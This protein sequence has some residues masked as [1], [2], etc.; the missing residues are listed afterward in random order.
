MS[1]W[2]QQDPWAA[3]QRQQQP[4][5][6]QYGWYPPTVPPRAQQAPT[7]PHHPAYQ[8]PAARRMPPY[9]SH[10]VRFPVNL[11]PRTRRGRSHSVMW[12]VWIGTHPIAMLFS[13]YITMFWLSM[14]LAWLMLVT[15]FWLMWV[16][17]VTIGWLCRCA[18]AAI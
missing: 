4:Q 10:L 2:Q 14:L 1:G 18:I 9:P 17:A 3:S 6:P 8:A 7:V 12:F 16:L 5:Q 11:V 15:E 13:L